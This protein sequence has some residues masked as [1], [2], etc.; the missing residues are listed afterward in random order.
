MHFECLGSEA[1]GPTLRLD[2]EVFAYAGKFVM[3]NSGKTVAREESEILGAIAFSEDTSEPTTV[4]LRYVTVR[5]D[6]RGEGIGPQ[7][8]RFTAETLDYERVVIAVNNPIA[9]EACYRAGFAY[10][11]DQPGIAELRL[12][13]A[14]DERDSAR[15]GEGFAV[16][17]E[18][19]LPPEHERICEE[20]GDE[21][22]EI[23]EVP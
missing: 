11:G 16:F 22:P 7:L 13:Y 3:S 2:H 9:Y 6:R 1:D 10:T 8:L 5:D 20:Y 12:V 18:R 17:A 19:D 15:Y 21:L 4:H 14:P 23:V